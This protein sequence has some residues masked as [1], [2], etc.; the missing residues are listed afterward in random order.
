MAKKK[1]K[2]KERKKEN[3]R[4]LKLLIF[5]L[6]KYHSSGM[7]SNSELFLSLLFSL[8]HLTYKHSKLASLEL[9]QTCVFLPKNSLSFEIK[10]ECYATMKD[11]SKDLHTK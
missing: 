9:F 1:K 8:S 7:I 11:F 5:V 3:L 6:A 10:S 4:I 2:K